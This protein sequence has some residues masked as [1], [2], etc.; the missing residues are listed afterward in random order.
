M[1]LPEEFG[2]L[3]YYFFTCPNWHRSEAQ[4][5]K[6]KY[7]GATTG[8]LIPHFVHGH[9]RS[10]RFCLRFGVCWL[11]ETMLQDVYKS[12]SVLSDGDFASTVR[13]SLP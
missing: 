8:M 1:E 3:C 11:P 6:A 9:M 5:F 13:R 2:P 12:L 7:W 4:Q 10:L